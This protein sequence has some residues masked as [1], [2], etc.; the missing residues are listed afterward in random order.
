MPRRQRDRVLWQPE[1]ERTA[2][3]SLPGRVDLVRLHVIQALRVL[4]QDSMFRRTVFEVSAHS[5]VCVC[6]S[7][8]TGADPS[9]L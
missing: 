3:S 6:V 7:G 2:A 4:L 8:P 5:G 1:V 9:C